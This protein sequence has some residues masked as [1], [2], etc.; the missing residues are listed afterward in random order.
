M[1]QLSTYI[2]R[3]IQFIPAHIF[4][5]IWSYKK[6]GWRA[7]N[8]R[9]NMISLHKQ[10]TPKKICIC[11]TTISAWS[12]NF[13][14][15]KKLIYLLQVVYAQ[16]R[17][18]VVNTIASTFSDGLGIWNQLRNE[19]IAIWTNFANFDYFQKLAKSKKK[20]IVIFF[21][22]ESEVGGWR[23]QKSQI[24]TSRWSLMYVISFGGVDF[25]ISVISII[26]V[27]LTKYTLRKE[28]CLFY[29]AIQCS[30]CII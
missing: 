9:P 10:T 17:L 5:N 25:V 27:V 22:P 15:K 20:S 14:C 24:P 26:L 12:K 6:L 16:N 11:L 23:L 29:T 28:S 18:V 30:N 19:F 2:S 13:V 21:V 4:F 7:I 8:Q 3:H 1:F